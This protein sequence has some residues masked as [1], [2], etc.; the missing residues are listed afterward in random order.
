LLAI[1]SK[2]LFTES[3]G[4]L[5]LLET[6]IV[7]GATHDTVNTPDTWPM[8]WSAQLLTGCWLDTNYVEVEALKGYPSNE[9]A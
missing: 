8:P 7:H 6:E 9:G 1:V 2:C 3:A 5:T 4:S